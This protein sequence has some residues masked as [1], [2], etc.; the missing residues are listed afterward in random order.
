[1]D[2]SDTALNSAAKSKISPE[3]AFSIRIMKGVEVQLFHLFPGPWSSPQKLQ[4]RFHRWI[5]HETPD[6]NALGE[7]FPTVFFHKRFYDIGQFNAV[8]GIVGL[9][10]GGLM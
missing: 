9:G 1:L 4:R 6:G 2:N 7:F 8:Q 10:H 5:V 3:G